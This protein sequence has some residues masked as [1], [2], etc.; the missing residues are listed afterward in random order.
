MKA[1]TDEDV[2][3]NDYQLVKMFEN[4]DTNEDGFLELEDFFNFWKVAIWEKEEVVRGNLF[5]YGYRNDLR[6]QPADGND[7]YLL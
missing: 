2:P 4:Y 5:N 3:E 7:D 6:R 1:A